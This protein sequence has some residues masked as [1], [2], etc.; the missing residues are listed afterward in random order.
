V[1][2]AHVK[3]G[4][5][6]VVCAAIASALAAPAQAA[7]TQIDFD[8]LAPGTALTSMSGVTFVGGP[9]VFNPSKVGTVSEPHAVHTR[10]SC[11]AVSCPSGASKLELQFASPVAS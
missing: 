2:Q 9:Q 8:D 11:E 7:E 3:L 5:G 4:S 1:A 6:A 10:G